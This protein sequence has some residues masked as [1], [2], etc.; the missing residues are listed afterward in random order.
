MEAS[1]SDFKPA[2]GEADALNEAHRCI[3]CYE[4]PCIQACPT[5]IDIPRFIS[6]IASGNVIGAAR[7]ISDANALGLSCAQACPTEVLCEGACVY[8]R[9][10]ERPV[11]IGKLQRHAME[12]AYRS[13]VE[14]AQAGEPTG[15]RVALVGAGPASL[16][17]ARELRILGHETVI[18]E[19]QSLPGGLNTHG[20]APYK[21]KARVSL[22]EIERILALGVRVEYGYEL[23]RNLSL[24]S[25]LSEFNAVFLGLGLGPDRRLDVPGTDLPEVLGAVEWISRLK[26]EE[27]SRFQASWKNVRSVLVIGGGNTALDAVREL[28]ALGV[29][30][31]AL[32]Y[33][34]GEEDMSGYRHEY[35][36][37]RQEGVEFHFHTRPLK[38]EKVEDRIRVTLFFQSAEPTFEETHLEVD[39]VIV[40][41]GQTQL[42]TLLSETEGLGFEEGR[43]V[44]NPRTGHPR[45]YAGGDLANGGME[46]VH[47]VAEGKKAAQ[48]IHEDLSHG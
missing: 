4:A 38:F 17:C 37:A 11:L 15:R 25:L 40:A 21:L 2:L 30:R 29:P 8:H 33:R 14:L 24:S 19:K 35:L 28:R 7:T 16:A 3:N 1:F 9:M 13:G 20:I 47:A 18:F 5:R 6:R 32:S 34:R 10:H 45:I 42:H 44:A 43:L 31:V 36:W 39:H 46:V 26:T 22:D 27:R 23:G 48:A 12:H 41:I